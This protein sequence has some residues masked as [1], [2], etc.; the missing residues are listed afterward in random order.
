MI[1]IDALVAFSTAWRHCA[2]GRRYQPGSFIEPCRLGHE[3]V[4]ICP[5]ADQ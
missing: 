1:V 2:A 4:V 3:R 5:F